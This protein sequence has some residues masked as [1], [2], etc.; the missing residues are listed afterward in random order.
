MRLRYAAAAIGFS[1]LAGCFS[2]NNPTAPP[3]PADD[4]AAQDASEPTPDS[5]LPPD[6]GASET[7]SPS[8][9]APD[10]T[11]ADASPEATPEAGPLDAPAEAADASTEAG[12]V[13][14]TVDAAPDAAAEA[15]ADATADAIADA[16]A[17]GPVHDMDAACTVIG[18][19]DDAQNC[20]YCGNACGT[21]NACTAGRC[22]TVLAKGL[23]AATGLAIDA[24]NAYFTAPND[25]GN[26]CVY[27]VPLT[28]GA[29]TALVT[30]TLDLS[31]SAYLTLLGGNVYWTLNSVNNPEVRS[32]PIGGGPA[33]TVSATETYP[34]FITNDGVGLFWMDQSRIR[35]G[36]VVDGG[37]TTLPIVYDA[38]SPFNLVTGTIAVDATYV[39]WGNNTATN[40]Q[41][42]RAN[43]ADGSN[44]QQLVT[45]AVSGV[46]GLTVDATTVYFTTVVSNDNGAVYSVPIT[47][48]P[49]TL[50]FPSEEYP[51]G[52]TSDATSLFWAADFASQIRK[53]PKSGGTASTIEQYTG[54]LKT[55]QASTSSTANY[56][57]LVVDSTYVYF[58]DETYGYGAVLKVSKN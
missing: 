13:D 37:V 41:I 51:V 39:Y 40:G 21:G 53:G 4:A 42:F 10:T 45:S 19:Q 55:A 20:G 11:T 16:I 38:G 34:S 22:V 25:P 28:G 30:P 27:S 14:A 24:N 35:Y 6:T 23:A 48:G 31:S 57:S 5:T 8:D 9:S 46:S 52:I 2:S 47:G 12:S 50:L 26:N 43:K 54:Y 3:P 15:G 44:V 33:G 7:A 17:D 29:K 58:L 49:A 56:N 32:V 1:T 36:N 18:F